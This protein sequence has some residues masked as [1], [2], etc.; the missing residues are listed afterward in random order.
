MRFLSSGVISISRSGFSASRNALALISSSFSLFQ[1]GVFIFFRSFSRRSR[2][3]SILAKVA[4][5]ED[6]TRRFLMSRS[7]SMGPTCGI[8]SFSNA[9]KNVNKRVHLAQMAM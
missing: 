9:P 8:A 5:H 6:R 1:F 4:D 3:F 2:R 7:G